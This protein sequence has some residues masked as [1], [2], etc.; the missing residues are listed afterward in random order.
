MREH[1]YEWNLGK[2]LLI[3]KKNQQAFPLPSLPFVQQT[4]LNE[5]FEQKIRFFHQ[6]WSLDPTHLERFTAV[7]FGHWG[8]CW[9]AKKRRLRMAMRVL[10]G[11]GKVHQS[12]M[13][14]RCWSWWLGSYTFETS[15]TLSQVL[16]F[17]EGFVYHAESHI[18]SATQ[19]FSINPNPQ[20]L[21][22]KNAKCV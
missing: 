9:Q 22:K 8:S 4:T 2:R 21:Q 17:D 12:F 5:N 11:D 19:G 7:S 16:F 13:W 14:R 6:F 1:Q 18:N 10:Q 15:K 20:S 3:F